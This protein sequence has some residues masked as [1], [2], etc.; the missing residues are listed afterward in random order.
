MDLASEWFQG[1]GGQVP[2]QC[3]MAEARVWACPSI[4]PYLKPRWWPQCHFL[5]EEPGIFGGEA[6]FRYGRK[7]TEEPGNLVPETEEKKH[8]D[9]WS[10]V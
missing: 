4:H 1:R 8:T 7:W 2:G 9:G 6:G 5:E 3:S 10:F